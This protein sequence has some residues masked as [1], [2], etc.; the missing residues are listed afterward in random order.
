MTPL[1]STTDWVAAVI[2]AGHI[3]VPG[4]SGYHQPLPPQAP[5][6]PWHSGYHQ[7]PQAPPPPGYCGY[8][9]PL[10]PPPGEGYPGTKSSWTGFMEPCCGTRNG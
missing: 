6:P 4:Y 1:A 3:E 9:Q 8:H 2:E 7:P 10:P 5:P